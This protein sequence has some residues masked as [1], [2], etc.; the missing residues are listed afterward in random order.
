MNNN[1]IL[2][3]IAHSFRP[4]E[5][6]NVL[7][8]HDAMRLSYKLL[9]HDYLYDPWRH[10]AIELLYSIRNRFPDDWNLSWRNDAYLGN[11]C[12]FASRY[13]ERYKAYIQALT[14]VS[15]APPELLVALA[16]CNGAPGKPPVSDEEAFKILIKV[17]REKPYKDVVRMLNKGDYRQFR[18]NPNEL[19]S[20]EELYQNLDDEKLPSMEPSF[21]NKEIETDLSTLLVPL[22]KNKQIELFEI[23]K[24]VFSSETIP[25]S[26]RGI[27]VEFEGE[28][29]EIVLRVYH[30][31]ELDSDTESMA[32]LAYTRIAAHYLKDYSYM[33][34]RDVEVGSNEEL[35]YHES[36]IFSRN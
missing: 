27:A 7:P 32:L 4:S 3:K 30:T 19:K 13:D 18:E 34:N 26:V 10:Y 23:A 8:F 20:W 29:E 1:N 25:S 15:P 33:N 2:E 24:K 12:V 36:W 17:A 35:P 9:T 16:S 21:L 6:A 28:H 22:T 11:A 14:K 5:L 31:N